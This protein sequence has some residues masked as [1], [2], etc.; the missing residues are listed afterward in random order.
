MLQEGCIE[1]VEQQEDDNST[2]VKAV[3][4]I[5]DYD[6]LELMPLK[7]VKEIDATEEDDEECTGITLLE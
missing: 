4:F 6:S 2:G 5:K 3:R 7:H 1:L